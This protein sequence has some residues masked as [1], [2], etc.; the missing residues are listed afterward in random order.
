MTKLKNKKVANNTSP[1]VAGVNSNKKR[2]DELVL[3]IDC[4]KNG[5]D[6][7][8]IRYRYSESSNESNQQQ[9]LYINALS[10]NP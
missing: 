5:K 9:Q 10:V 2:P 6:D 4:R 1:V 3:D 8:T 7:D